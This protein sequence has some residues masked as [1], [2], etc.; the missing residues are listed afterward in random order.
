M[1]YY[2][3]LTQ[4][5]E[6]AIVDLVDAGSADYIGWGTGAG[7]AAKGSTD[8]S[9]PAT[10]ARVLAT[11]TQPA[12]DKLQW[13]G[14]LTADAGKTITNAGVFDAA[15]TG[16][17]PSGGTPLILMGN[18]AGIALNLGDQIQFTFQLEIT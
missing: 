12:A 4:A 14:T 17:P 9:T 13:V 1:A 15:G 18:F 7:E 10:E 2:N 6:E 8:L 16:S 5:G 3:I 11:R